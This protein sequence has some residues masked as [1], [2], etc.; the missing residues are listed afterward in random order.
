[1]SAAVLALGGCSGGGSGDANGSSDS[2]ASSAAERRG[3]QQVQGESN[4]P[5]GTTQPDAVRLA[6]QATFGPSEALVADMQAQ[7]AKAWIVAQF[8]LAQSR[9]HLG[10][11]G[12]PDKNTQAMEFCSLPEQLGN[13]TC[14]RDYF[15]SEPLLW[16]FYRNAVRNPDQLR[17]RVALALS[18]LLVISNEEATGTYGF[19]LYH[20]NLLAGAFGNYRQLLRKVVLSPMMGQYLNHVNNDAAAPNENFARELLQLFTIGPCELNTDGTLSGGRCTATYDNAMVRAYAYALTGWTYP[21][22]GKDHWA[23]KP[24]G[25]NCRFLNGDMVPA[26][27]TLRDTE[28]RKLLAGV[29]VPA[30]S[31]ADAA[32]EKVLD[33]LMGHANLGPFV[34]RHLIKQLVSGNPSPAYV[35]R[36]A[37]AFNAGLYEDIGSGAK[38]DL[39]ATVAAVL[40]DSE[41][42]D[43]TPAA[44]AGRLREPIQLFT[45]VIRA[46]GG[47][48]DGVVFSYSQGDNLRQH[49]FRAPSV[50]NYYPPDFP[51]SGTALVGPAFGIHNAS[52]ALNRMNYLTLMFDYEGATPQADVPGAIGTFISTGAW[53]GDAADAALLVDRMSRLLLGQPL[54]EP[55]RTKVIDAVAFYTSQNAPEDW[56]DQ[57]VRRAGWLVMSS[58]AYQIV[59]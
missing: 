44:N 7:G 10:G 45:G 18:E 57:R 17:Q 41:A 12:A 43:A 14:F 42:R 28:A 36:V 35:A 31:T 50:F 54:A 13:P 21:R 23:C 9:Y 24:A 49:V 26:G 20:N 53:R 34:G 47:N 59:R 46:I 1:M 25:A 32:L 15:T 40:L 55:V 37:K 30:G 22:G 19:R 58:P 38:G 16:D 39:S 3:A 27:G 8:G 5:A 33:S 56:R 52:T 6:H 51:V 11:D 4:L 29:T 48:T 2:G